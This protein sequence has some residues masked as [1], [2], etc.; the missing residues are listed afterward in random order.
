MAPTHLAGQVLGGIRRRARSPRWPLPFFAMYDQGFLTN[1]EAV[2]LGAAVAVCLDARRPVRVCDQARPR[3][4]RT[5]GGSSQAT[6]ACS[7]ASTR[8][9]GRGRRRST[10]ARPHVTPLGAAR[11]R[12]AG[13]CD[14]DTDRLLGATGSIGRQA[15]EIV[16][17]NPELELCALHVGL[18]VRSTSSR[19]RTASSTSRSAATRPRCSTPASPTSCS[20]RS[21][22]LPA[23]GRRCGRSSTASRSRSP[24]RRASSPRASSRV[25]AQERGGG[26]LLPVDSEHSALFQ[27]LEG[28]APETVDSLVLTASG[29]PFRGRVARRS[30]RT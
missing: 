15:I 11:R 3:A 24:T 19:L 1:W 18:A 27:C 23:C 2:A 6:A 28:R 13:M 8:S 26:L 17:R 30:S 10:G 21:S 9:C 20:T 4:S 29:G 22:D 25:A 14:R 12:S 5:P 16:R 7:I